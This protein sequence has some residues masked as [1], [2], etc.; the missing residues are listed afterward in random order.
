MNE[1]DRMRKL[2]GISG[3]TKHK[4][5]S[6]DM[7]ESETP[8]YI[9]YE[10]MKDQ[11]AGV[12][13]KLY[14]QGKDEETIKQMGA[15]IAIHLGYDPEDS[16]FQ[17]AFMTSFTDASLNGDFDKDEDDYTDYSMR[18]GE[19]GMQGGDTPQGNRAWGQEQDRYNNEMYESARM[20][21]L[22]GILTESVMAAPGVG[23][24]STTPGID[25]MFDNMYEKA[26]PGMEDV[27]MNLKKEYPG[28]PSKAFSTAWSIYNKKHAETDESS[29]DESYHTPEEHSKI[30]LMAFGDLQ[31]EGYSPEEAVEE[32][33][34]AFK[35]DNFSDEE[36]A[37]MLSVIQQH[38]ESGEGAEDEP[39]LC[40][41]CNGSGEGQYD[42]SSCRVCGG[43]GE[44]Q[45]DVEDD[46]DYS[47]P[48]D[49]WQGD[50][51]IMEDEAS[52]EQVDEAFDL[53]NGYEDITFMKPGDFF[54]DGADSPV[55]SHTGPSGARMGDN[56]EQKKMEVT[57]A[58]RE[59]VYNYRKFLKESFKK[60]S[61][62][63]SQKI[64]QSLESMTEDILKRNGKKYER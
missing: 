57:E 12:L 61:P 3:D 6:G 43:S 36:I 41:A 28:E 46:G 50:N 53:N 18:Q 55:V 7:F 23:N 26:P 39:G 29:M 34:R 8:G 21:K 58:H 2:A 15:R 48:N 42:G 22:S 1:L 38:I 51:E 5:K 17:D 20:R 30:A 54:P 45:G 16:I 35:E 64:L 40:T 19:T 10:Q 25:E 9:R 47:D 44:E 59:L 49:D 62:V 52:E 37:H 63:E 14:D 24:T 33:V 13:I 32:F 4:N 60:T 11:I 27:V 56:P 31:S